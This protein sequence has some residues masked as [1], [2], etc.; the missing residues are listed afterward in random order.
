LTVNSVIGIAPHA[1]SLTHV[2]HLVDPAGRLR[3]NA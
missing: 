2:L 1:L 3:T